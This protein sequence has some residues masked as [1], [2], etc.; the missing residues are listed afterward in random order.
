MPYCIMSQPLVQRAGDAIA[1]AKV[2][3]AFRSGLA[4]GRHVAAVL[5]DRD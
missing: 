2:E 5:A 4:A 1:G 3:G